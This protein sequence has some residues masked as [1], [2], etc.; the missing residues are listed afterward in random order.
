MSKSWI[1]TL[2]AFAC[3]IILPM[4][5]EGLYQYG[6]IIT[7]DELDHYVTVLLVTAGFGTAA[8]VRKQLKEGK[9]AFG[10]LNNILS[11]SGK[12]ITKPTDPGETITIVNKKSPGKMQTP[13]LGPIGEW[14][15]TNF[16]KGETG[17]ILPYGQSYLW[18]KLKGV[19]S[20]VTV[21]LM[22]IDRVPI[23]ID[24]SS[25][26]DEDNDIE[27]TRLEM[28]LKSGEPLPRGEYIIQTQGDRGSS[29]SQGIRNDKF[30]II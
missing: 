23:Q 16:K 17:N 2:I 1:I 27:T 19:R 7:P 30:S 15:Q 24:Q 13:E 8:T 18:V 6:I 4:A 14:Y 25:E 26:F 5:N 21:K 20:Y 9:A 22:T 3:V 12:K 10:G 28:F 11:K 29:D